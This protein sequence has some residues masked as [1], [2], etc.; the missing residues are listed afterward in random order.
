MG[1]L[2]EP[3]GG[4]VTQMPHSLEFATFASCAT[5]DRSSVQAS[6]G[7]RRDPFLK[8]ESAFTLIELL[9]VVAIIAV[10]ATLTVVV[11][12]RIREKAN[13]VTCLNNLRQIGTALTAYSADNTGVMP[14]HVEEQK[15]QEQN[16]TVWSARLVSKGYLAE[17]T[18]KKNAVFLC[19]FDPAANDQYAEAYRSYAYNAGLEGTKPVYRSAID[20]AS[21]TVLLSEWYEPDP[22]FTPGNHATW[23]G[24]AWGWR[25]A[26]GLYSHHPD[27]TSGVLFYD[28]H[29]EAVKAVPELP[30][31]GVPYKWSFQTGEPAK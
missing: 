26:G 22:A 19:P 13:A 30:A 16:E 7:L 8:S 31:T 2:A 5:F 25:N 10:L 15:N 9:V 1:A 4:I 28:L 21:I 6:L 17:P 12:G 24:E 27:G 29:A 11:L 18:S 14:P 23:D 3:G 20:N